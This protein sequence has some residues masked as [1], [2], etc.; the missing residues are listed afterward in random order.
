MT[1]HESREV[2]FIVIFEKLFQTETPVEE[3]IKS[4]DESENYKADDFSKRLITAVYDN[5]EAIDSSIENNLVGWSYER[6]SKVSKAVL[7][8]AVC[9]IMFCDDIPDS[10]AINEAV[11][12]AKKYSDAGETAFINGVLGSIARKKEN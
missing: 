8:L 2:A 10:V 6:I 5:I 3:I 1:R 4:A 7:R 12:I 11:E 9:E